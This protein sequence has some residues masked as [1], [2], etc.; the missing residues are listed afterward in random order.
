MI[1]KGLYSLPTK[2]VRKPDA[3]PPGKKRIRMAKGTQLELP[4]EFAE[5]KPKPSAT[6][7]QF[8]IKPGMPIYDWYKSKKEEKGIMEIASKKD[9]AGFLTNFFSEKQIEEMSEKEF[10]KSLQELIDQGVI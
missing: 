3:I 9:L 1:E 5:D 2:L 10:E 4:L 6:I 7:L 8:E